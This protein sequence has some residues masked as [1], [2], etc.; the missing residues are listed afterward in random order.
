MDQSVL[1]IIEYPASASFSRWAPP[2]YLI[3]AQRARGSLESDR[4]HLL[5]DNVSIA[6]SSLSPNAR[7]NKSYS[8]ATTPRASFDTTRRAT[9]SSISPDANSIDSIASGPPPGPKPFRGFP[10]EEAY[11]KAL[12][13]WVEEKSFI[14]L[15]TSLQG[16]YGTKTQEYYLNQP[17]GGSGLRTMLREK[18]EA[19]K[20]RRAT[21]ANI[22][23]TPNEADDGAIQQE[24]SSSKRRFSWVRRNSKLDR[25][26][27]R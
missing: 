25:V 16:W 27:T 3:M 22:N 1:V 23:E 17:D 19:K 8:N 10:S 13:D 12:K 11:L 24:G 9:I 21:V 6:A 4:R 2:P 20:Q 18:R 14:H 26:T 15:D 5:D 7:D